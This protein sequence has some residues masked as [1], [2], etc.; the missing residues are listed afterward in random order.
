MAN[1]PHNGQG[2]CKERSKVWG[3][4]W[5]LW[6]EILYTTN[7][8]HNACC[9]RKLCLLPKIA[10][11]WEGFQFMPRWA[12]DAQRRRKGMSRENGRAGAPRLMGL[13]W[14]NPGTRRQCTEWEGHRACPVQPDM[15]EDQGTY[16]QGSDTSHP[17]AI[18]SVRLS[19][20]DSWTR[21]IFCCALREA[22][23]QEQLTGLFK[24][25]THWPSSVA[26]G[27]SLPLHNEPVVSYANPT[28]SLFIGVGSMSGWQVGFPFC[29]DFH[30]VRKDS[31]AQTQF[32]R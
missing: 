8:D 29:V 4:R 3:G 28:P 22:L 27:H 7:D 24:K 1:G 23:K 25:H 21:W 12:N 20:R 11:K 15:P 31:E 18:L 30:H 26:G 32:T 16:T 10:G 14:A 2:D 5:I 9:A 13:G 17:P 19:H 6:Y